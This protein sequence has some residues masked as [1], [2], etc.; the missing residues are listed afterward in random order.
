MK[1]QDPFFEERARRASAL[2]I[3]Q[4]LLLG[5]QLFDLACRITADGIRSQHPD[6]SEEEV[7]S[8]LR[9][10]LALARRLGSR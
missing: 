1:I 10:R 6:A 8:M 2:P 5:A 3:E 4:K 7:R 9:D